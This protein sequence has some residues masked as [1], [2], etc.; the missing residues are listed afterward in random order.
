MARAHQG[1]YNNILNTYANNQIIY[2]IYT[3]IYI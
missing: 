1:T 3:Y 2:N